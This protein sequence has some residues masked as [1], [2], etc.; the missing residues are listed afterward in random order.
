MLIK[1]LSKNENK[2][3]DFKHL[4]LILVSL[5]IKKVFKLLILNRKLLHKVSKERVRKKLDSY[6]IQIML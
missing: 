3:G 4:L 6:E 2:I 5:K 1:F